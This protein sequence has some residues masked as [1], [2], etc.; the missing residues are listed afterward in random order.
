MLYFYRELCQGTSDRSAFPHKIM[1]CIAPKR[2]CVKTYLSHSLWLVQT[3]V[4]SCIKHSRVHHFS[5]HAKNTAT[6]KTLYFTVNAAFLEFIR[7]GF[8]SRQRCFQS[9]EVLKVLFSRPR[10]ESR[11][12]ASIKIIFYMHPT[13]LPQNFPVMNVQQGCR[14]D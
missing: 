12:R 10:F 4:I 11:H 8:K 14:M 2:Y 1:S 6:Q 5:M 3:C 7:I 13:I 9:P